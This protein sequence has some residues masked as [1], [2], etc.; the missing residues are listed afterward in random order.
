MNRFLLKGPIRGDFFC[1]VYNPLDGTIWALVA[2]QHPGAG[3]TWMV[4]RGNW[5][6]AEPFGF[7]TDPHVAVKLLPFCWEGKKKD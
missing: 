4:K 5:R 6:I 7:D 1:H 2:S 3:S